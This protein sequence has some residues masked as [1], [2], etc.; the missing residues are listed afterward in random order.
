MDGA[1]AFNGVIGFLVLFATIIVFALIVIVDLTARF[2]GRK[3]AQPESKRP[4]N[5]LFSALL[6]LAFDLMFLGV[7]LTSPHKVWEKE[8]AVTFDERMFYFW[9]PCHIAGY[10]LLALFLR[11]VYLRKEKIN[12]F[13]DKLR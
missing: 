3:T 7:L 5:W 4:K 10:L 12:A 6:F 11:F 8:E 9:I 13:V 2:V 1:I